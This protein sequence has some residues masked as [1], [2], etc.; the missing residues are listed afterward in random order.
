M[1]SN[2]AQDSTTMQFSAASSAVT[3]T[4]HQI[5]RVRQ[6]STRKKN[7]RTL[8]ATPRIEGGRP[9]AGARRRP[10]C[11]RG[12]TRATSQ[13]MKAHCKCALARFQRGTTEDTA[14]DFSNLN[15]NSYRQDP[16]SISAFASAIAA[17]TREQK[18]KTPQNMCAQSKTKRGGTWKSNK[19][20][21]H[22]KEA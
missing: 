10:T 8:L 16:P 7:A 6:E 3:A 19:H 21:H 17:T 18:F 12:P 4:L 15:N 20:T 9:R 11:R 1:S 13:R 5:S 2:D 22:R 14:S